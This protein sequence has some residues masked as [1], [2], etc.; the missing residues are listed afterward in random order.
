MFDVTHMFV[1]GGG[2]ESCSHIPK[3]SAYRFNFTIHDGKWNVE[4]T[5]FLET[6]VRMTLFMAAAKDLACRFG[7]SS[8]V[9]KFIDLDMVTRNGILL[10]KITSAHIMTS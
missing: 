6:N 4:S 9:P 2:V 3:V 7:N 10:T 1:I 5:P 8:S